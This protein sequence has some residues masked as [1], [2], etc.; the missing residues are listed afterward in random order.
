MSFKHFEIY[1]EKE[2]T[3]NRLAIDTTTIDDGPMALVFFILIIVITP[4]ILQALQ[5]LVMLL[6][7]CV[8]K[9][10][11][12]RGMFLVTSVYAL[13]VPVTYAII[14][15]YFSGF[16]VI[17]AI[18][19]ACLLL[20]SMNI[21]TGAH[22]QRAFKYRDSHDSNESPFWPA[23]VIAVVLSIGWIVTL[24]FVYDLILRAYVFFAVLFVI[25]LAIA[26]FG[27][28]I[29]VGEL[30]L[31]SIIV[32]FRGF[33]IQMFIY[34]V[35]FA[36]F[37]SEHLSGPPIFYYYV[38]VDFGVLGVLVVISL[39]LGFGRKGNLGGARRMRYRNPG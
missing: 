1:Y 22:L 39:L 38:L 16:W 30:V 10:K 12:H 25:D 2:S 5:N 24:V 20:E 29:E 4:F 33:L 11:E 14:M 35:Y 6:L 27:A 15:K 23:V 7:M 28:T 31:P 19:L 17:F 3:I 9:S 13:F 36:F 37:Y 21:I 8:L 32:A 26:V 34:L 18:C